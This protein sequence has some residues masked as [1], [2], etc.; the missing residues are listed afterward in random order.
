MGSADIDAAIGQSV[1]LSLEARSG[2]K[3]VEM[4]AEKATYKLRRFRSASYKNERTPEQSSKVSFV[5]QGMD[6]MRV[7]TLKRK[8][9]DSAQ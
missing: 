9:E 7:H 2:K 8:N 6:C 1:R 5:L 3:L 4:R